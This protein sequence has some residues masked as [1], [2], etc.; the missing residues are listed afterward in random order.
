MNIDPPLDFKPVSGAAQALVGSIISGN[1]LVKQIYDYFGFRVITDK[2]DRVRNKARQ[3]E[4]LPQLPPRLERPP[5]PKID[6]K[7][8]P[9][10]K[11]DWH[12]LKNMMMAEPQAKAFLKKIVIDPRLIEVP[13][14]VRDWIDK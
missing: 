9:N 10:P 11:T 3:G 1:V 6:V 4:A 13:P 14:E 2:E 5:H 12:T 7:T 8:A